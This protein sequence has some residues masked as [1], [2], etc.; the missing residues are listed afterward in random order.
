MIVKIFKI[1]LPG[2]SLACCAQNL[3]AADQGST[4]APPESA[5][6]ALQWRGI[7][8]FRGG[9]AVAVAGV[10]GAPNV[11]YFGAAA[12][13]IWKTIDAGAT[14]KPLFDGQ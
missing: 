5:Y 7:G 9:R 14:W 1:L 10:P 8:P 12:G 6:S 2:L 4:A 11:F 13:G 3:W